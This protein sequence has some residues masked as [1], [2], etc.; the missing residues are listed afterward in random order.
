MRCCKLLHENVTL[1]A[2]LV[3]NDFISNLGDKIAYFS[4][5]N[6]L[7]KFD[8]GYSTKYSINPIISIILIVFKHTI[9]Q[10]NLEISY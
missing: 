10:K 4:I 2:N 5:I 8:Q 7:N 9:Q 6:S 3:P 1:I